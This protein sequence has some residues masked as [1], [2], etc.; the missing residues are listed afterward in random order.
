MQN[1]HLLLQNFRPQ[2]AALKQCLI[3]VSKIVNKLGLFKITEDEWQNECD[4]SEDEDKE[5]GRLKIKRADLEKRMRNLEDFSSREKINGVSSKLSSKGDPISRGKISNY[6]LPRG[7]DLLFSYNTQ[8]GGGFGN[9]KNTKFAQYHQ[10][11]NRIDDK[12]KIK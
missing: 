10:A 7:R 12:K 8:Y 11:Y 2:Q 9:F 1:L 6:N 4:D 3:L 5:I